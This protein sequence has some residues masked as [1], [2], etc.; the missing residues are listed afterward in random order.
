MEAIQSIGNNQ[1]STSDTL[2][3]LT[4]T[5]NEM[6]EKI[7]SYNSDAPKR[8]LFEEIDCAKHGETY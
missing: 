8:T 5:I 3:N 2:S 4:T 6:N 7:G 1:S